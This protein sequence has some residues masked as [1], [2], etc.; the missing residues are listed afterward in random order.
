MRMTIDPIT[1]IEGHLR[2]DCEVENG[3]VAKSW[4]SEQMWRGI[5]VIL[6][7]RNARDARIF[8]QGTCGGLTTL[9]ACTSWSYWRMIHSLEQTLSEPRILLSVALK[10]S[11]PEGERGGVSPPVFVVTLRAVSRFDSGGGR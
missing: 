9:P 2:I 5:E 8:A 3:K 11:E 6:Q 4:S 10:S 7:G 1:R